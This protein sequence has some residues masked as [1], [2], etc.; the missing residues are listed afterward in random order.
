MEELPELFPDCEPFPLL[1]LFELEELAELEPEAL[2]LL[3]LLLLSPLFVLAA[4]SELLVVDVL[5]ALSEPLLFPFNNS[6]SKIKA[7]TTKTATPSMIAIVRVRLSFL[8]AV[9]V[10]AGVELGFASAGFALLFAA[11]ALAG[12][13]P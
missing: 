1:L 9:P 13:C 6:A 3:E 11:C 7:S 4:E 8:G 5:L 2:E 10:D 12:C